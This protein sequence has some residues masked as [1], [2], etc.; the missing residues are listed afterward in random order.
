MSEWASK[1]DEQIIDDLRSMVEALPT[2]TLSSAD[3][4]S[5]LIPEDQWHAFMW[6]WWWPDIPPALDL[7]RLGLTT[8]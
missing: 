7:W 4:V 5:I 8:P 6:R 2:T 1:T 3:K